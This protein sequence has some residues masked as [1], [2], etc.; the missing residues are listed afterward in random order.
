MFAR[1]LI[2]VSV[3][4]VFFRAEE[5]VLSETRSKAETVARAR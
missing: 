4:M 3:P 5:L 1:M 2:L